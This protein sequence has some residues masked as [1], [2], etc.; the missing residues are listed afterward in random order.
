L[1]LAGDNLQ[2]EIVKVETRATIK[3][4][5]FYQEARVKFDLLWDYP[6]GG[7]S[8]FADSHSQ[9]QGL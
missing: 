2:I 9:G 5:G 6:A 3:A 8:F 4:Y 1:S 7:A